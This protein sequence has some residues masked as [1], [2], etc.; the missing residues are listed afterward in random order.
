MPEEDAA[1]IERLR[2]ENAELRQRLGQVPRISQSGSG[3]NATSGGVAG[4]E[5]STVVGG[6]VH[7]PVIVAGDGARI[8]IGE[9]PIAMTAVRRESALGRYLSHVIGRNRYLQLQ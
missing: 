4:G 3:A 6:N 2:R 8:S 1:E 9:R 7:G 5:G